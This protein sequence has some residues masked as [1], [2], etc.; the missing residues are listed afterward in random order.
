VKA[1]THHRKDW[2]SWYLPFDY[3]IPLEVVLHTGQVQDNYTSAFELLKKFTGPNGFDG[4][5]EPNGIMTD[6]IALI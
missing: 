6:D 4:R 5:D 3:C 1:I 2:H